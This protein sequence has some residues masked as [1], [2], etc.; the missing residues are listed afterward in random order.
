MK[1]ILVIEDDRV[2]RLV[3]REVLG[4]NGYE[5]VEAI[6][7]TEG[8][9]LAFEQPPDL[10]I[11]DVAMPGPDGFAVL[12]ALREHPATRSIPLVFL[13]ARTDRESV[14]LGM[15]LGAEDYITKPFASEELLRSVA[16]RLE[17]K[18]AVEARIEQEIDG[19]RTSL[20]EALPH[21]LLTPLSAI[22]AIASLLEKEAESVSRAQVRELSRLIRESAERQH[23][24]INRS[25]TFAEL[26]LAAQTGGP[27]AA[28]SGHLT[29]S[30]RRTIEQAATAVARK[31]GRLDDLRL[32][33]GDGV[34]PV[35][36]RWLTLL[37]T[38]LCDNALKFSA[39][40]Q[41]VQVSA[42][43]TGSQ[44]ELAV[45]DEGRGLTAEQL[46]LVSAYRQFGRAQYQQKGLGLGLAICRR[47]AEFHGGSL[48]VTSE[49]RQGTRVLVGFSRSVPP[50]VIPPPG[51]ANG[52]A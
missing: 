8:L 49:P 42:R 7:G 6:N 16:A 10:I 12:K 38:E 35:E 24:L 15:N 27:R 19:L 5:V 4:L 11:C 50:S 48:Q 26:E 29:S 41:R 34:L 13:T 32:A 25:L 46:T 3:V 33:L 21:E 28:F 17:R 23:Q 9:R 36:E 39:P 30:V 14:R 44:F 43:W 45:E 1:K 47:I 51:P 40:R 52:P 18:G 22:L 2:I 20:T 31:A 37:T